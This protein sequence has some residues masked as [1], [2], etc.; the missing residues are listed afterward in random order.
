MP[1]RESKQFPLGA[2]LYKVPPQVLEAE[3]SVLGSV[4]IENESIFR[5][6]EVLR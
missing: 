6:I 4:L 5:V 2:D 1:E 3:Q